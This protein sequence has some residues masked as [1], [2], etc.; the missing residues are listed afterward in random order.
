M[1]WTRKAGQIH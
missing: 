1:I